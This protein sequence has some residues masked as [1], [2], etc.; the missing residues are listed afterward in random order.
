VRTLVIDVGTTGVRSAIVHADGTV[1]DLHYRANPPVSPAPGMVEFDASHLHATVVEL[2]TR[3]MAAHEVAAV[4]ITC[5]RAST[6]VWRASTATPVGPA[7]GW[8]D[9]RTVGDCIMARHAHGLAVAPNQTATKAAW[10]LSN[11]VDGRDRNDDDVRIGTVDSWL[12][13]MLTGGAHHV[14]DHTNAAVTGLTDPAGRHWSEGACAAFGISPSQLPRIVDTVGHIGDAVALPGAPPI[15]AVV[16]DQQA[17]LVGQGCIRE[18][19]AKI[20]FGTGGMLDVFTGQHPPST[21]RRLAGGTFPIVAYSL[22]DTV[23]YG[24]EA[25]MLSA[26]SNI[27]WLCHDMGLIDSPADSDAVAASCA[28]SDGVVYVPAL[29]GLGTPHWDYGA[30]GSL[31]GITRGTTRAHIVRA[32]L[33]GVAHRGADLVEA[34]EMDAALSIPELR[35][36]GGMS[37]NSTFVQ[38][39]A[40]ASGRCVRVSAHTEA[41]T[42]GAGYLA[43]THV[44]QWSH[45]EEAVSTV[46]WSNTVDPL[47]NSHDQRQQWKEAVSRSRAWIPDLSALD[48]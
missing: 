18:G 13:W 33:E 7:I 35:I 2:A 41:T 1:T 29:V 10:L 21:A 8:Q 37:R 25:I 19:A 12:V 30:R 43:G 46:T 4:G 23:N 45:L 47:G 36:D 20:T 31:F 44:G 11:C 5:Q 22:G 32:V 16:G 6:V 26:G 24:I 39:L 38:A 34:A 9:L 42:I 15:T 48:F 3:S 14:T 17:S 27:E 40:D 28:S